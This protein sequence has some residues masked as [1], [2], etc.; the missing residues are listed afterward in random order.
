MDTDILSEKLNKDYRYLVE[1]LYK[2]EGLQ[3]NC[4]KYRAL[5]SAIESVAK[6]MPEVTLNFPERQE[7][8]IR[9]EQLNELEKFAYVVC[10]AI[11]MLF[12]T[13]YIPELPEGTIRTSTSSNP[14]F[15]N[16]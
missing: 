15:T 8:C 13:G 5:Y 14:N 11:D 16:N 6:D 4:G 10:Y 2:N 12:A 1:G 7:G 3:T 9:G